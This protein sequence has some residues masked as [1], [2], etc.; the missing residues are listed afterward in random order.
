MIYSSG[1]E[2]SLSHRGR[3][4]CTDAIESKVYKVFQP[5]GG[6][7]ER[8]AVGSEH[9]LACRD[10]STSAEDERRMG[11][12]ISWGHLEHSLSLAEYMG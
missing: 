11:H 1:S 9:L 6:R 2:R 8:V 7:G 3:A 12:Q 4:G 5:L 10:R